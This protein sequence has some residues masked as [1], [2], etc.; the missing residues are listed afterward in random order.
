V[1]ESRRLLIVLTSRSVG[2]AEFYALTMAQGA[3]ERGFDVHV[4]VSAAPEMYSVRARCA[5]LGVTVHTSEL[6]EPFVGKPGAL[7][8]AAQD[9][10][11]LRW[12][13][14]RWP[15]RE[16]VV[17][18]R[19]AALLAR[20]RPDV[21]HV[22]AHFGTRGAVPALV[23][24]LRGFR[25]VLVFQLAEGYATAGARIRWLFRRTVR[26]G[27]HWIAVTSADRDGLA[28]T[29]GV[30][31]ERVHL[32][33]NAVDR[34]RFRPDDTAASSV[35]R[36]L[37]LS[38]STRLLVTVGRLSGQKGYP[39]YLQALKRIF[40][41]VP[42]AVALWIGD[43]ELRAELEAGIS[44]DPA[45]QQRV[46]LLGFR[47]D[48]PRLVA[49]ADV[50]VLPSRYEGLPFSLLEAM[51]AGRPCVS[52]RIPGVLEVAA[53]EREA[54]LAE[55][56]DPHGLADAVVRVLSDAELARRLGDAGFR[57]VEDFD[58]GKMVDRTIE[59]YRN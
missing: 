48:V 28:H 51:A 16:P 17:A 47:K 14:S 36:E 8:S 24:A 5:D 26:A 39:E 58:A 34:A 59:I 35:R 11:W 2:G 9:S 1:A 40:E 30:P 44:S 46:K 12:A 18:I 13:A 54:L 33:H 37:G 31:L 7:T 10:G 32:V 56:G 20:V 15:V 45:L 43:G 50:F 6:H 4:A 21:V 27:A 29:Y 38:E 19:M 55:S 53:H 41:R 22:N 52:T 42:D 49:A 3:R 57:R 23:A 25:T